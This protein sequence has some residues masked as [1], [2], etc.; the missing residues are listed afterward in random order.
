MRIFITLF[1]CLATFCSAQA[2]A[3]HSVD[4]PATGLISAAATLAGVP[5]ELA[6]RVAR[7]ESGLRCQAVGAGRYFGPL[8]ILPASA[9]GFGFRGSVREL[10]SCGAGL[11]YGM[12]HLAQCYHLAGGNFSLADRCH[13]VGPRFLMMAHFGR[14]HHHR[15]HLHRE[16]HSR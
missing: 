2:R 9:R 3:R 4:G 12:A 15:R 13:Q 16:R 14:Y 1:V 5:V 8:Q 7:R 11:F 6:I 10:N